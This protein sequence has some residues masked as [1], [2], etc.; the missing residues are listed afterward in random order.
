MKWQA[1]GHWIN[2]SSLITAYFTIK[3][4]RG[5]LTTALQKSVGWDSLL[6]EYQGNY[7]LHM[8]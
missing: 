5:C 7:T 2:L 1:T 6:P 8:E 3:E 4:T